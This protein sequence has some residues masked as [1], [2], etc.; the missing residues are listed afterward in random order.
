MAAHVVLLLPA[1]ARAPRIRGRINYLVVQPKEDLL[2]FREVF[3]FG[4]ESHGG[5]AAEEVV[6]TWVPEGGASQGVLGGRRNVLAPKDFV[7]NRMRVAV[8]ES[9]PY[10]LFKMDDE[11]NLDF[12]G[13]LVDIMR[14]VERQLNFRIEWVVT[15]DGEYG[16]P[17]TNDSWSGLVGDLVR[18]TAR[19]EGL[20][21]AYR[22]LIENSE[23][24]IVDSIEEGINA[25]HT[26]EKALFFHNEGM[27]NYA[28]QES[29]N[30]TW[31]G[32]TYFTEYVHLGYRKNLPFANVLSHYISRAEDHGIT[33]K[34]RN[35]W[36]QPLG[37]CD[38]DVTE[39]QELGIAKTA[40]AFVLLA[41]GFGLS[42]VLLL[43]ELAVI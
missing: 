41:L 6:G 9:P 32:H 29:C 15:K 18:Q 42:F 33:E 36:R 35:R 40:S 13:F 23:E 25:L 30:Y 5:Q 43:G 17:T 10:V 24:R 27:V 12:E 34:L 7:G 11:G 14:V 37:S 3:S 28:V 4:G 38:T 2:E 26:S 22:Q 31:V 39:F 8:I 1:H 20:R 21:L 19:D 16:V